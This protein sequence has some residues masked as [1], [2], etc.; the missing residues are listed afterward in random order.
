MKGKEWWRLRKK[1]IAYNA[2][3][4]NCKRKHECISQINLMNDVINAVLVAASEVE[5]SEEARATLLDAIKDKL[6]KTIPVSDLPEALE[7]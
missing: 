7:R 2:R 5:G 3:L 1:Q 6:M 4:R